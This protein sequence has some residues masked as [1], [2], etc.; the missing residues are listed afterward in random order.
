MLSV[1]NIWNNN[2][3]SRIIKLVNKY[4]KNQW[5]HYI[6]KSPDKNSLSYIKLNNSLLFYY[7]SSNLI[8]WTFF[9]SDS[10]FNF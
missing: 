5:V 4:L 8:N 2:N 6:L 7:F 1:L 10:I 3:Y 9:S